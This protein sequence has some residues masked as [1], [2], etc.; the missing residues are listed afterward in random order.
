MLQKYSLYHCSQ[1]SSLCSKVPFANSCYKDT[2]QHNQWVSSGAPRLGKNAANLSPPP[3]TDLW[4]LATALTNP[5]KQEGIHTG[6]RDE[7]IK[8]LFQGYP[9]HHGK[10]LR[11]QNLIESER[12][13]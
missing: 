1:L 5:D 13:P 10:Q 3:G 4:R 6:K 12:E 9:K 8:H 2:P 7:Q 11:F